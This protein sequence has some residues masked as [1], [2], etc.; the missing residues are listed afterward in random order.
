TNLEASFPAKMRADQTPES[1]CLKPISQS[2]SI[3]FPALSLPTESQ[4]VK[5]C[6]SATTRERKKPPSASAMC[7]H[8]RSCALLCS[9]CCHRTKRYSISL[10]RALNSVWLSNLLPD[11]GL[12]CLLTRPLFSLT[13]ASS[14][15]Q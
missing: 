8:L 11:G 10:G 14:F 2:S 4:F 7:K 13:S 1:P 3:N 12:I 15:F 6:S 5:T 9:G